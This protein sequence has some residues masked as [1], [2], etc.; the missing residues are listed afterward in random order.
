MILL[1]LS[2]IFEIL[3]KSILVMIPKHDLILMS[4]SP[5]TKY[6]KIIDVSKRLF[7]RSKYR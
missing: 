6:T 2:R 5:I 1:V 4:R 7:Q 3:L